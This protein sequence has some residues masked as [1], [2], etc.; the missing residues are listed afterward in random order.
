M[1]VWL[2]VCEQWEASVCTFVITLRKCLFMFD[3]VGPDGTLGTFKQTISTSCLKWLSGGAA[4]ERGR[5]KSSEW[6]GL[7][8]T[9]VR[10]NPEAPLNGSWRGKT[11]LEG[12]RSP[13]DHKASSCC[14]QTAELTFNS[15]QTDTVATPSAVM[16]AGNRNQRFVNALISYQSW[17]CL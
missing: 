16:Q 13:I 2:C 14:S 8:D 6:G 5:K 10:S 3:W 1:C 9:Y 12:E 17:W 4:M 15:G 7:P 11:K